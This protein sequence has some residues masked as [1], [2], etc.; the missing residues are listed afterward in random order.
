LAACYKVLVD[1]VED[2]TTLYLLWCTYNA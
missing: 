1:K 2:E